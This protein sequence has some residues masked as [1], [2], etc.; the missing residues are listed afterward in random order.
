MMDALEYAQQL[1]RF[2]SVSCRS[3]VDISDY[4]QQQ[5]ERQG[6][7]VERLEYARRPR[8]AQGLA[9]RQEGDRNQGDWPISVTRMWFP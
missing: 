1:V 4:V 8:C 3:N 6:C 9:R 7:E 2:D 5:L